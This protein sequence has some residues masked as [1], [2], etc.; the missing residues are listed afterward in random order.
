M[1]RKIL[2]SWSSGKDSAWTLHILQQQQPELEIAGLLTT[3][4]EAAGRVTMHAVRR[5]L[6][7]AQAQAAGI[8]L[9][10]VMLPYPCPNEEYEKRVGEAM[11]KAETAGI[12]HIAFGDLFLEDVRDYRIRQFANSSIEPLFPI[13]HEPT[14][15]LARR[16]VDSGMKAIVTCLDPKQLDGSFAARTF[17]HSFLDDLPEGVDP[18]GENGEFHTCVLAGPMYRT[19]VRATL[20]ETVERDGFLFTD[21]MSENSWTS[22]Q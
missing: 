17:D 11:Q 10:P 2:L 22:S 19:P 18:C 12:T 5:D 16:M 15:T 20:G 9:W 7:E 13:W 14:G 8:S 21:L 1:P 6:V 3:F 4:N